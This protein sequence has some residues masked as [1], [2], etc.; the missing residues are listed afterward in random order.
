MMH[1]RRKTSVRTGAVFATFAV[2]AG[3]TGCGSSS[4]AGAEETGEDG[5][6]IELSVQVPPIPD[7]APLYLAEEEGLFEEQ[8]LDVTISIGQGG[9]AIAAALQAG[10]ID[11]GFNNYVSLISGLSNGLPLQFVAEG[12]RG[13]AGNSGVVV[14]EGSPITSPEDLRGA[15]IGIIAPG[16][17]SD[18]TTN[19]RLGDVGLSSSDVEYVAVPLPNLNSAVEGGQVDGVWL[20]EPNSTQLRASGGTLVLDAYEET[21][22]GLAVG[23][24]T[25]TEDWAADNAEALDRFRA[26]ISAASALAADDLEATSAII[27][28]YTD[29]SAEMVS[30]ITLPTYVAETDASEVQRV[31]DLMLEHDFIQEP[32]EI[33]GYMP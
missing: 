31:A 26:A 3:L 27:P 2:V 32:L 10:S 21:T 7:V 15:T 29:L 20:T 22:E 13:V 12:T 5:G 30:S 9:S 4:D 28:T 23:G 1:A 11:I 14:A 6:V 16:S 17:I 18:L 8:G 19:V 33:S 25:V 24:Y